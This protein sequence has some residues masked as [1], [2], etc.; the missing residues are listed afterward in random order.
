VGSARRLP[1]VSTQP[2]KPENDPE[3]ESHQR[4]NTQQVGQTRALFLLPKSERGLSF[5]QRKAPQKDLARPNQKQVNDH[6][7]EKIQRYFDKREH[8]STCYIGPAKIKSKKASR[9][10]RSDPVLGTDIFPSSLAGFPGSLLKSAF[11]S[12]SRNC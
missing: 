4:A 9:P 6:R 5:A 12:V 1:A 7:E 3:Q 11:R 8:T 2:P 10:L